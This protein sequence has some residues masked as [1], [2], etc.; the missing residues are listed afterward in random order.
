[1]NAFKNRLFPVGALFALTLLPVGV[2]FADTAG[3]P[4]HT[5]VSYADLDL[6]KRAGAEAMYQ[7]LRM[8]AER[9]CPGAGTRALPQIMQ[10]KACV[11]RAIAEAVAEVSAPGLTLVHR[12]KTGKREMLLAQK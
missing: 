3:E 10:Q 9:V 6:S 2:S 5:T 8:A 1:M 4:L 12:E 7:R 11:Q